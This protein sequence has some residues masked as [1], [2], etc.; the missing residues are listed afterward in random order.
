MSFHEPDL[1]QIYFHE[2]SSTRHSEKLQPH[3]EATGVP[4]RRLP[5][6]CS[7]WNW[8]SNQQDVGNVFKKGKG[9]TWSH[10]S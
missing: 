8:G 10:I 9:V 5:L 1:A 3:F 7:K 2:R 6:Q 4:L